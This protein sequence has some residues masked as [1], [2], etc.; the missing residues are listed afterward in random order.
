MYEYWDVNVH[1]LKLQW[2][3]GDPFYTLGDSERSEINGLF[4]PQMRCEGDVI[5]FH[6]QPV[7]DDYDPD[8]ISDVDFAP[9]NVFLAD[10]SGE[11]DAIYVDKYA[12]FGSGSAECPETVRERY[13]SI[14][15]APSTDSMP[16]CLVM[17]RTVRL[18]P[19]ESAELRYAYGAARPADMLDWLAE[20][21]SDSLYQPTREHW[22]QAVTYFNTGEDPVLTRETAWHSAY[23]LSAT[24][25]NAYYRTFL[26]PQGSAYLYLHG[27]DGAPRDQA[28]FAVP[29]TYVRPDLARGNL[30]LMMGLTDHQTG[31]IPYAFAGH[32]FQSDAFIHDEPSDLDLF[33]LFALNEYLAATGDFGFL[34]EDVPFYCPSGVP[35]LPPGAQGITV[36]DHAR[37][38]VYHLIHAVGIGANGLI[39]V[40]DGD[41]S[42]G[43]VFDVATRFGGIRALG[44]FLNSKRS[45]ESI[46]NTQ[47]ALY[48]LPLTAAL[49]RPYD[50]VLAAEIEAF[51]DGL[52][53]A[54]ARQWNGKWY[55]R[56]VLRDA[57]DQQVI[58]DNNRINLEAQPWALISG[59]AARAG[60]EA[61]LIKS[62]TTLLDD[63]SPNGAPLLERGMIWP[64]VSQLLTWGYTRSRPNL[65]WRSLLRHTFAA[66]SDAFPETW[67]NVWSGPDGVHCKESEL[68]P[69]G[70]W[71]SPATPMTDFPVMNMNQHAMALLALIRV[72]GIEPTADG[73]RIAPHVPRDRFVLDTDLLRLDVAPGQ[74]AGEYRAIADGTITLTIRIPEAAQQVSVAVDGVNVTPEQRTANQIAFPLAIRHAKTSVFVVRWT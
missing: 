41:W 21:R 73:L 11:P 27:A 48:V 59:A 42:D 34:D 17:R 22:R 51:A 65:A 9:A 1:Q 52:E 29:L 13:D 57:D 64:A 26:T 30:K 74:V 54:L 62:L 15:D 5:R 14:P 69:G 32:G 23:L 39:K 16:Y 36:L 25:F 18:A 67:I 47:M 72:C 2:L 66:H 53:S 49:L 19:G 3:R 7:R 40:G 61:D 31:A 58:V 50:A 45:G 68:D 10:L 38:A 33:F 20:F 55:T 4:L 12:F 37:A 63:P 71:T 35:T 43:V 24:V 44:W 46:P 8:A 56:A 70:T 6:Q 28:L 60:V